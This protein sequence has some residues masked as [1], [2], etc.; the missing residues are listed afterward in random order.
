[1]SLDEEISQLE[2]EYYRVICT[3]NFNLAAG[4]W[5]GKVRIKRK[6]T[7]EIV[8]GG[9]RVFDDEKSLLEQKII[10]KFG[11]IH[12]EL[13]SLGVPYE[14][15]SRGR[16]ILVSFL[17]LE[18]KFS[19]YWACED[20]VFNGEENKEIF[21]EKY[22]G[23]WM[24]VV[25][26]SIAISRKIETLSAQER[27]EM[28]IIPETVFLDPSDPWSL[29]EIDSRRRI[30]KFFLNPSEQEVNMHKMQT[31]KLTDLFHQL[32]WDKQE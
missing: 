8:K 28:L 29:D 23:F 2:C 13:Q 20:R 15:N 31:K 5:M 1:M 27:L 32:G 14:W 19:E 9:F 7:N 11:T 24:Q 22:A 25:E 10:D 17:K 6:D 12:S 16:L 30:I 26:D 3:I 21:L 4:K 18:S